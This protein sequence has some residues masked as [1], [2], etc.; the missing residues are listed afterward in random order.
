MTYPNPHKDK[1]TK[2]MKL[3]HFAKG[4]VRGVKSFVVNKALS[5]GNS[6]SN[7]ISSFTSSF[8][9]VKT[10]NVSGINTMLK[11]SP[12]E[13]TLNSSSVNRAEDDPL[14]FQHLQYP[15]DL[16]GAELG[17]WIL[18]FTIATNLGDNPSYNADLKLAE[19]DLTI[20]ICADASDGFWQHDLQVNWYILSPQ[21]TQI[22]GAPTEDY[23][24]LVF[25][26]N[27]SISGTW[28]I[29]VEV[30]DAMGNSVTDVALIN[31]SNKPPS[32]NLTINGII[33]DQ[34]VQTMQHDDAWIFEAINLVDH[35]LK[36]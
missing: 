27:V 22:V 31:V 29:T 25:A 35:H 2:S 24:G 15:T 1:I 9:Q 26:K 33:P 12:F 18:F 10:G 14:G 17:N 30:I 32:G 7:L 23:E 5:F 11:K 8:N 28:Q 6:R 20:G 3:K 36:E 13:K 19:D 16:T 34:N 21:S 4:A